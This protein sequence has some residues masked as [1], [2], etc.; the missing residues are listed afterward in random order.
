M[1]T[2][3]TLSSVQITEQAIETAL[4]NDPRVSAYHTQR[5]YKADLLE[6][7]KWRKGQPLS[8]LLVESYAAYLKSNG[9]SHSTINRKLAAIRWFARKLQD[10]AYE[11]PLEKEQREEIVLQSSRVAS[12]EDI[13]G[14]SAETGKHITQGELSALLEVCFDDSW[15]NTGIRDLA[16]ITLAWATGMRRS[17]ICN[18]QYADIELLEDE[19]VITIQKSKGNKS[20]KA[21]LYNGALFYLQ[22]W[23]SIRGDDP[24]PLFYAIRKGG[25]IQHGQ[26][27]T[28]QSLMQILEKRKKEA[29]I[30]N[31]TWHDF[32]RTFAGNLLETSDVS[33][34][35]KLMGHSSPITT[36]RYDKRDEGTRKKAVRGLHI[37]YKK[38]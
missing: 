36:S 17:E 16:I 37:P 26:G 25:H 23:L 9:L 3:I 13:K 24:G 11:Y 29:G 22:D 12:V 30:S 8:K 1:S 15:K 27:L 34:V 20:R 35:Q 28:T 31:L 4:Q 21:Y 2:D 10:L 38:R 32:R 14:Q 6:F 5:A 7:E 18:L 33:T 19:A